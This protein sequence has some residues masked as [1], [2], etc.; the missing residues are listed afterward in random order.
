MSTPFATRPRATFEEAALKKLD[1]WAVLT[2]LEHFVACKPATIRAIG[3]REFETGIEDL[4]LARH[5]RSR[6]RDQQHPQSF[7]HPRTRHDRAR[8]NPKGEEP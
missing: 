5:E 7:D 6:R 3:G 4:R 1:A 2:T 8:I